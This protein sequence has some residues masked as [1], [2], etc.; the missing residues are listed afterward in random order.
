MLSG[1]RIAEV[2]GVTAFTKGNANTM[3]RTCQQQ[4]R[5]L[6]M[7]AVLATLFLSLELFG[8]AQNDAVR[9][10]RL[11]LVS[12]PDRKLAVMENGEVI[13][14][15]PVAVGAAVSPSPQGKF[16]IVNRVANPTYYHDGA[17]IPAGKDNPV[18]TRWLG[19][20]QKGYGIHGTNAPASIGHA[21]SHG[22]VRLRNRDMEK[23]FPL[24]RMGD[25]VEIRGEKDDELAQIFG[26]ESTVAAAEEAEEIGGQ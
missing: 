1:I 5:T 10:K 22:C 14:R 17:V 23:L 6:K 9:V 7:A 11:V 18:G 12:I 8:Q 19:L 13:A 4:T 2:I 26:G 15:F 25:V 21:A 16:E 3:I 20:N 24:L